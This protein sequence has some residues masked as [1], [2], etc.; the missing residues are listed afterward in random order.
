MKR[1]KERLGYNE[2]DPAELNM[3]LMEDE[4]SLKLMRQFASYYIKREFYFDVHPPLGKI[5]LGFSGILSGYNG[6]F[7]F[8]SGAKYPSHVN[9]TGMRI[10]AALFGAGMVPVAYITGIQLRLSQP[11][12]LLLALMVLM[13]LAYGSK[14]TLKNNGRGGGL[15]HSH[16]QKY[17]SGSGQQQVTCYHHKDNNNNWFIYKSWDNATS[18]NSSAIEYVKDGDIVRLV[19]EQTGRNL[20]SHFQKAPVSASEYE[21]SCYGNATFGDKN[22]HWRIEIVDDLHDWRPVRI[23]AL[24]TRFR[25]RHV[26]TNCLL[27]SGGVTLPEWG[28]KQAEV[29]F[30]PGGA[31]AFRR[32]FFRDFADL[33]VAM[34]N[35]NNALTPDPDREPDQITSSPYQWPLLL[36]GLRMCGWGDHDVKFFLLGHPLIWWGS[37]ASLVLFLVTWFTYIIRAHRKIEDWKSKGTKRSNKADTKLRNELENWLREAEQSDQVIE[38][39]NSDV[40]AIIAPVINQVRL[41]PILVG[42]IGPE[43]ERLYGS[44]LRPYLTQPENFFVI[45]SDFCHWGKRF[46]YTPQ[47][48]D[49]KGISTHIKALDHEAMDIIEKLDPVKFRDYLKRTR[50][51]VCGRHPIGV[52]LNAASLV[53]QETGSH[54]SFK[55]VKYAQSSEVKTARDSSVSYA[56]AVFC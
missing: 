53:Q 6:S 52:F 34:W 4:K 17:P 12:A 5:L 11:C 33:N 18:T 7:G 16:S 22:D 26:Q 30:P 45:S 38:Y 23:K 28:F 35:S 37:T 21:V 9:Y 51:T 46:N 43:K 47:P 10:F 55:F 8:E 49:G 19:H 48:D 29:A 31:K 50:N 54:G 44:I 40:K 3:P 27:R 24:S 56:S 1:R 14:V 2:E 13:E 15:L 20:H 36:V 32:N 41:V 42:S 25:L 39:Q